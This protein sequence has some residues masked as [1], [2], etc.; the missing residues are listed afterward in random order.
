MWASATAHNGK[1]ESAIAHN[2]KVGISNSKQRLA[3]L[4]QQHTTVNWTSATAHNTNGKVGIS[5]S[6]Q[7]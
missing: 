7:R 1:L 4:Q 2:S 6:T 5:N 3:G